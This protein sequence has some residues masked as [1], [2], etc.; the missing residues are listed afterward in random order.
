MPVDLGFWRGI[1]Q[2]VEA[3]AKDIGLGHPC[4]DAQGFD[5][6]GLKLCPVI[7]GDASFAQCLFRAFMVQLLESDILV[8]APCP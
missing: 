6:S 8:A 5:L 3:A 4:A 2:D 1:R 7:E